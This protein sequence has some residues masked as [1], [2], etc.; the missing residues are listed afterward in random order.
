[1]YSTTYGSCPSIQNRCSTC[2]REPC[3]TTQFLCKYTAVHAFTAVRILQVHDVL[4]YSSSYSRILVQQ[5]YLYKYKGILAMYCCQE[6]CCTA[7]SCARLYKLYKYKHYT[8][9]A[10]HDVLYSRSYGKYS[11]CT[12]TGAMYTYKHTCAM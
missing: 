8:S 3:C 2:R 7:H 9:T 4:L 12:S 6:P 11:S 5:L 1:M 10:V